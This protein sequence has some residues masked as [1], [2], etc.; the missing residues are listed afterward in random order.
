[1]NVRS[2][3]CANN[4]DASNGPR[5]KSRA[6]D[7]RHRA[8]A[9]TVNHTGVRA[10][11]GIR[12]SNANSVGLIAGLA[13]NGPISK[14]GNLLRALLNEPSMLRGLRAPVLPSLPRRAPLNH[15][16]PRSALPGMEPTSAIRVDKWLWSARQVNGHLAKPARAVRPGDVIIAFVGGI[17][18]TVKVRALLERRVGAKRVPDYL[19]DLTPASEYAKLRE[20]VEAPVGSRP[21][22]TG[23]P[24]KKDRR[25]LGSFFGF[26]E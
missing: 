11:H 21:K 8:A 26:D 13:N 5:R 2:K 7:R 16:P 19:E 1:M 12:E 4:S 22:G 18:R 17:T 10:T 3:V 25:I 20:R 23:R 6:S 24:T 14:K 15:R 9:D